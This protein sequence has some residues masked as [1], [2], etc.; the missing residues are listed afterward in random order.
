MSFTIPNLADA[1]FPDQ[2]EPDAQD[3]RIITDAAGLTGV[4]SGCA[5]TAQ[6]TPDMTVAVAAGTIISGGTLRVVSAGNVTI[7]AADATNPRFDLVVIDASGAKQRRG[8][9]A[10][11]NPVFP[12]P[13][14]GDAVLAA[15]YVPANDTAINSTQIVDK[16]V[17]V[18]PSVR[19]VAFASS[20]SDVTLNNTYQDILSI[21]L[22]TTG[23][24]IVL[25]GKVHAFDGGTTGPSPELWVTKDGSQVSKQDFANLDQVGSLHRRHALNALYWD[26]PTAASHT[27]KLQATE[28]SNLAAVIANSFITGRMA[29]LELAL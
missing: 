3:L 20:T 7:T 19:Q 14:A 2:A 25:L 8:G 18:L 1:G 22:T 13:T 27:Y 10:A 4:V 5:V 12:T 24:T 9:T 23:G 29:I 28:P 11:S 21:T 26:A 17:T 6:G 16:R 15:V